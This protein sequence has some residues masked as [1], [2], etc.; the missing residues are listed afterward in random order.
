MPRPHNKRVDSIEMGRDVKLPYRP[1]RGE[2]LWSR[3]V[4]ARGHNEI[5][6]SWDG[7]GHI[8]I[9]E[10]HLGHLNQPAF[11]F[12]LGLVER[13]KLASGICPELRTFF[14]EARAFLNDPDPSDEWRQEIVALVALLVRGIEASKE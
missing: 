4:G 13:I 12:D 14:I 7:T 3:A 6:G 8:R 5:R 9:V 10:A 2:I 11:R 1:R